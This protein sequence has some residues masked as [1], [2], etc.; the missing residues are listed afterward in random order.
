MLLELLQGA[1]ANH[2]T[3]AEP[4][5]GHGAELLVQTD[6]ELVEAAAGN[7]VLQ[8]PIPKRGEEHRLSQAITFMVLLRQSWQTVFTDWTRPGTMFTGIQDLTSHL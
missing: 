4:E 1:Q 5:R 2:R 3:T 6:Q 8:V 7:D